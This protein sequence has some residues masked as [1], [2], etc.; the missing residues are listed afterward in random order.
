MGSLPSAVEYIFAQS[1]SLTV[2]YVWAPRGGI[3]MGICACNIY[4]SQAAICP[5]YLCSIYL[6]IAAGLVLVSDRKVQWV[7]GF[8]DSAVD[9]DCCYFLVL[10][11]FTDYVLVHGCLGERLCCCVW[12]CFCPDSINGPATAWWHGLTYFLLI[13][14]YTNKQI[15]LDWLVVLY[16]DNVSASIK[17]GCSS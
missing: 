6:P 3:S 10:R 11:C 4:Y 15:Q 17:V 14:L 5:E 16:T 1:W 9:C 12:R 2:E 8:Q 7:G 13:S